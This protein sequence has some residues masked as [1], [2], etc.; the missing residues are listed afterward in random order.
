MNLA[1]FLNQQKQQKMQQQ[2]QEKADALKTADF[3]FKLMSDKNMPESVKLN[4]YKALQEIGAKS[5][6][7]KLPDITSWSDSYSEFGKKGSAIFKSFLKSDYDFDTTMN[8]IT[9]LSSEAQGKGEEAAITPYAK[10]IQD[11]ENQRRETVAAEGMVGK[12]VP[13]TVIPATETGIGNIFG[14]TPLKTPEM[15]GFPQITE[16]TIQDLTRILGTLPKGSP[17][18][19]VVEKRIEEMRK[20]PTLKTLE[21]ILADKVQKGELSLEEAFGMK[22]TENLP[23]DIDKFGIREIGSAYYTPKG[24]KQIMDYISTPKGKREFDIFLQEQKQNITIQAPPQPSIIATDKGIFVIDKRARTAKPVTT[25]EGESVY[26][27]TPSEI[28]IMKTNLKDNINSAKAVKE[29]Y[30]IGS[31]GPVTGRIKKLGVKFF[32]NQEFA[33][34]QN[35]VGQL[36]TIIYGLSGKQIN[37]AEQ[38][39]LQE[40]IIPNLKQPSENFEATLNEF[41]KWV[42]RRLTTLETEYPALKEKVIPTGT[43]PITPVEPKSK[44]I[45]RFEVIE[46]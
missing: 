11:I 39:W 4:S 7:A 17:M 34:L 12:T 23:Q 45:G 16:P 25:I 10:R 30:T 5:G 6:M 31:V 46:R 44:K 28:K 29:V 32:S 2:Q 24:R 37:E 9:D 36:R 41:E 38:K 27:A 3:H 35:R 15:R 18:A 1:N 13:A 14:A 19:G 40:E 22:K 42:Q 43:S 20:V 21:N 26:K 33:K 8:A